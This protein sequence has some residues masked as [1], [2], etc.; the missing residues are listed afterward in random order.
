MTNRGIHETNRRAA[1]KPLP[2]GLQSLTFGCGHKFKSWKE[3]SIQQENSLCWRVE[4]KWFCMVLLEMHRNVLKNAQIDLILFTAWCDPQGKFANKSRRKNPATGS[5]HGTHDFMGL[6]IYHFWASHL[7]RFC[8]AD[9]FVGAIVE[10]NASPFQLV[11]ADDAAFIRMET[12]PT[13]FPYAV[14]CM[15]NIGKP[16]GKISTKLWLDHGYGGLRMHP[17]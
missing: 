7:P 1:S 5:W 12:N 14:P 3:S 16:G 6:C 4:G 15:E 8:Q 10:V 17:W 13:Q 9:F 11:W 2:A